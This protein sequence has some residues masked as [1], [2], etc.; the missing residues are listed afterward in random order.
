MGVRNGSTFRFPAAAGAAAAVLAAA[1]AWDAPGAGA[2]TIREKKEQLQRDL[3]DTDIWDGWIYDDIDAGF[4]RAAK[5]KK[6]VMI[7]FR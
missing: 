5:E 6:P 4:A 7:V 1:A 3:R 2:E